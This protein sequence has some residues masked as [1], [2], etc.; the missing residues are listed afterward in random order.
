MMLARIEPSPSGFELRTF[1][2]PKY[3]HVQKT[4]V[5]DPL[6]SAN[7]SWTAGGLKPPK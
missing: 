7:T 2:C 5:K 1:E 4:L 6:Q 3:E